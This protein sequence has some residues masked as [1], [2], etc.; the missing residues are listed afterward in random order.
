MPPND[1]LVLSIED[2]L[3]LQETTLRHYTYAFDDNKDCIAVGPGSLINHSDDP[4]AEYFIETVNGI[5]KLHFVAIK[6]IA[7]GEEITI[8]YNKDC[9]ID[10]ESMMKST[11]LDK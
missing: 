5:K 2:T 3:K 8:D 10:V 4:N 7:S 6:Y 11:P 9:K 1:L